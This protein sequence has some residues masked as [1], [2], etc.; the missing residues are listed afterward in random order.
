MKQME[1]ISKAVNQRKEQ[2][3]N[4]LATFQQEID[5]KRRETDGSNK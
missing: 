4:N 1:D 2:F 3:Y 5:L